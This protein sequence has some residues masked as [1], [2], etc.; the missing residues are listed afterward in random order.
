MHKVFVYYRD[1]KTEH[2]LSIPRVLETAVE[3]VKQT[4]KMEVEQAMQI[5]VH[6]QMEATAVCKCI[7][8]L[9]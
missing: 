2:G 8:G 7:Y 5:L 6:Q 9:M 4:H 1:Y 3:G